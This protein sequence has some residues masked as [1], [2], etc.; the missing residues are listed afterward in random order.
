MPLKTTSQID[1]LNGVEIIIRDD[2]C[3]L[4]D[5]IKPSRQAGGLSVIEDERHVAW[6]FY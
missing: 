3:K 4:K 5:L 2:C 1:L 6:L